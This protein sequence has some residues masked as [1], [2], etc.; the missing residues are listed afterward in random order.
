[1]NDYQ[2][3]EALARLRAADPASG[4]HPDLHRISQRLHGKTPL[5]T[6]PGQGAGGTGFA[7]SD[8]SET[9]VRINDPSNRTSRAG[10]VVAASVA[11]LAFG[12]GGYIAGV[13]SS[14]DDDSDG[15][16][17]VASTDE[18]REGSDSEDAGQDVGG[19][20]D[21][22]VSEG[23]AYG[24]DEMASS[25]MGGG[26]AGPVVPVAGE[27]LSTERTTGP[28]YAADQGGGTPDP[29]AVLEEYAAT[30]GIE[31]TVE[32][33]SYSAYVTDTTDGRNLH[34]YVQ[35]GLTSIDFS[36]PAL[37]PYCEDY[38]SE[39]GGG[40]FGES[41]PE[42]ITCLPPGEAPDE[43]TAIVLAQDF[44]ESLGIDSEGYEFR[45]DNF[46]PS[47]AY[48]EDEQ[49]LLDESLA[50][51]APDSGDP[52]DGAESTAV[53]DTMLEEIAPEFNNEDIRDV[54]VTARRTDGPAP[55]YRSWYFGVTDQGVAYASVQLGDLVSLGDYE[56]ISPAEAVERVNDIR[57]QQNGAYIPYLE[58]HDTYFEEWV[59]PKQLP[60]LVAGEPIP[61]PLS[62]TVVTTAEL[63]TGVVKIGRAHV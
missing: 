43:A 40:W 17:T 18:E 9:A 23:E 57:F 12:G 1:M 26:Y 14:G 25:D 34:V 58:F 20:E 60:P 32:S 21:M 5:G 56:V 24:G 63:H 52:G 37:D 28:V 55:D 51:S 10:L 59:E 47:I 8:T 44:A 45:A 4:S 46:D 22:A 39:P 49:E 48:T 30:L 62:E 16:T 13:A 7:F 29:R 38:M 35:A 15:S 2:D 33:D 19:S 31:G 61:F 54:S 36:D 11:A 41:G 53:P 42:S 27:E 3:D 50:T 6:R